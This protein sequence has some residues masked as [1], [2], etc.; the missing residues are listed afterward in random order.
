MEGLQVTTLRV[1][2]RHIEAWTEARRAIAANYNDLLP[3]S[4]LV[5]PSKMPWA[6]HRLSRLHTVR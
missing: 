3:V 4:E 6:R 2:L 1:K 5:P